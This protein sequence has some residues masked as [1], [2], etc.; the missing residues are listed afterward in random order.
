MIIIWICFIIFAIMTGLLLAGKGGFLIAGYNTSSPQ[1]KAKFDEKK[2][3]RVMG[4]G[5]LVITILLL[6]MALLGENISHG[7][8]IFFVVAIIVD[9]VVMMYFSNKKCFAEGVEAPEPGKRSAMP[10]WA[11]WVIGLTTLGVGILLVTGDIKISYGEKYVEIEASYWKDMGI[12]YSDIESVE[13][14]A[15]GVDGSRVAGFG[16]FKLA[17]GKFR[18]DE[19]GDYTRYTYTSCEECVVL[20]VNERIFVLNGEDEA[21]T[22]AIYEELLKR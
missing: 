5:M 3:C 13:Y 17:M 21:S 20:T 1:E 11:K 22:K 12:A 14:R 15:E 8:T 7:F 18:N 6:I 16:S 19:F 2:L 9:C 4:L 10:N